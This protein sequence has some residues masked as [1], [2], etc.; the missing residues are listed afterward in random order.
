MATGLPQPFVSRHHRPARDSSPGCALSRAQTRGED[1]GRPPRSNVTEAAPPRIHKL[2]VAVDVA[3]PGVPPPGCRGG[4]PRGA[5]TGPRTGLPATAGVDRRA[6]HPDGTMGEIATRP[7]SRAV[8]VSRPR[9]ALSRSA[10][11][12]E[13]LRSAPV[14][15]G[16]LLVGLP[17]D[18]GSLGV[19]TEQGLARSCLRGGRGGL[20]LGTVTCTS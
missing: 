15:R 14:A 18:R 3:R 8:A 6:R 5:T 9:S 1:R 12:T 7:R 20:E 13:H 4:A 19:D 16:E 11:F 10:Y 17:D 2:G